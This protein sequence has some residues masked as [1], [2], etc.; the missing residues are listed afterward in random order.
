M[1]EICFLLDENVPLIIQAL[2]EQRE[3]EIRVYAVGDG[4]A[5]PKGTP[6]AEILE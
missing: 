2:L 1:S 4:I 5:P 6:D 3:P